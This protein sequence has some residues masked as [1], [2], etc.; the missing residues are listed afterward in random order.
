MA[1]KRESAGD[2]A[3]PARTGAGEQPP[4][5]ADDVDHREGDGEAD[6]AE[7]EEEEDEGDDRQRDEE[8]FHSP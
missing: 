3:A 6:R 7:H 2:A 5:A 4:D 8:E 1:R